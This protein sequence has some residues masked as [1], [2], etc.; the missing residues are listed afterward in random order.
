MRC[1]SQIIQELEGA[2]NS[3]HVSSNNT[4]SNQT[5]LASFSNVIAKKECPKQI[6]NFKIQNFFNLKP[7]SAPTAAKNNIATITNSTTSL[8]L[9][10]KKSAI[11][12]TKPIAA[13]PQ[14]I[15]TK[16]RKKRKISLRKETVLSVHHNSTNLGKQQTWVMRKSN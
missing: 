6:S 14:K 10:P 12:K 15:E 7:N 1:K 13:S 3:H 9:S 8:K 11:A 5:S 4:G 2:L 16:T